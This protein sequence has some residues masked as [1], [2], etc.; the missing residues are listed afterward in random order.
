MAEGQQGEGWLTTPC[1]SCKVSA[2]AGTGMQ[3][4]S[5]KARMIAEGKHDD[6]V[7]PMRGKVNGEE[8]EA[9]GPTEKQAY[10][11]NGKESSSNCQQMVALAMPPWMQAG[12][13]KR[14]TMA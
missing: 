11:M 4:V 9:M 1:H 5:S 13:E 3:S 14:R 2:K 7:G 10:Q 12:H 8:D 6:A